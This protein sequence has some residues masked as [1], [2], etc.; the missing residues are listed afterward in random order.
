MVEDLTQFLKNAPFELS[1]ADREVIAQKDED[2]VSQTW[3]DLK[4][5]IGRHNLILHRKMTFI[6]REQL[7][8]NLGSLKRAPS[9][10]RNYL[11]WTNETLLQYKSVSKYVLRH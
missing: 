1:E 4:N 10:M 11:L 7:Q 5:A 8:K 9:D 2:F 3:E 6:D